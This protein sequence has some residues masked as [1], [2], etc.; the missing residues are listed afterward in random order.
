MARWAPRS[1]AAAPCG[2]APAART[3]PGS[4]V[5]EVKGEGVGLG[6]VVSWGC[7]RG[8][9]GGVV[10]GGCGFGLDVVDGRGRGDRSAP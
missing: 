9:W 3:A 7:G 5:F 8:F 10:I 6:C 2:S 4:P 1:R